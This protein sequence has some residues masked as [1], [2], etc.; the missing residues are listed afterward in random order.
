MTK[1]TK[2]ETINAN[3]S[4]QYSFRLFSD[5]S[6]NNL[7]YIYRGCFTQKISDSIITIAEQTIETEEV[8]P[9]IRKRLFAILVECL[10]NILR[11]QLAIE[12]HK[13]LPYSK[14]FGIL[15]LQKKD[16]FYHVTS[17]NVIETTLVPMLQQLLEKINSLNKDELKQFY[18]EVLNNSSVSDKGDA[19]LGLIDIARKSHTELF[20][21]F[22]AIDAQ[23]SFFYLHTIIPHRTEV[24][25][26]V[27]CNCDVEI[28]Q[29]I[30]T[31]A[32][33]Q[34]I[35]LAYSGNLNQDN[36]INL[37]SATNELHYGEY[38]IKK[39]VFNIMVEMLQNIVKHGS[40]IDESKNGN[41]AIFYICE[42][43]NTIVLNCGNYIE[44]G[45]VQKLAQSI[46][47]V[48]SLTTEQLNEFYI[49]QLLNFEIDTHKESG[50]GIID[51]SI[52]SN[53]KLAYNIKSINDHLS[54]FSMQVK[55]SIPTVI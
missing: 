21:E 13:S 14:H 2:I 27:D 43:T 42:T 12:T 39:K 11:H 53:N 24:A 8:S 1:E 4:L 25:Q 22:Q 44:N 34:N 23:C 6:T 32:N 7:R 45:A 37:L 3:E 5:M 49:A 36:L 38:D 52:K 55:V 29:N 46:D 10:Q 33:K 18:L 17:G 19:G 31:I 50:L 40:K 54:F 47:Y 48:N 30:H 16:N 9:H 26:R 20:Y 28:I 35:I 15:A 51:L 41:P